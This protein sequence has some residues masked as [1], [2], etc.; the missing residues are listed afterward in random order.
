MLRDEIGHLELPGEDLFVQFRGVWVLEGEETADKSKHNDTTAPNVHVCAKIL[1]P[2]NHFWSS[3]ARAATSCL[4]QLPM[5]VGVAQAEVDYF[6]VLIMIKQQVLRFQVPVNDVELMYVLD[7]S[8]YLLEELA[9]LLLLEAR[10]RY[11][12]VEEL[13]ATRILHY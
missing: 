12:I 2:R 8:D 6:D 11:Y 7:A 13:P 10:V 4:Q 9:C 5:T 1:L 3:V